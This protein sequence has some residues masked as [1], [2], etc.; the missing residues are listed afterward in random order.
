MTLRRT[1]IPEDAKAKL[2]ADV[3]RMDSS[4]GCAL[5]RKALKIESEQKKYTPC[6]K[7]EF[8]KIQKESDFFL[9]ELKIHQLQAFCFLQFISRS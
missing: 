8:H 3:V 2:G 6:R 5:P 9:H 1:E 7:D 4:G